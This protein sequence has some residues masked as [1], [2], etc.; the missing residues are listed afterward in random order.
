MRN[1]FLVI[2]LVVILSLVGFCFYLRTNY[3]VP[4]LMYHRITQQGDL[5]LL[6]VSPES[7]RW[8]M[9]FLKEHNYNVI[10][11]SSLVQAMKDKKPLPRNTV[12]ITFDDGYEDNYISAYPTIEEYDLPVT[13]FMIAGYV[14]RSD[15][16]TY[17]QM[18]EMLSSGLVDI[19]SH[20]LDGDY[21]PGKTILEL[22][23]EISSS[24]LRLGENLKVRID[25]F[26]YPLGGFSP[27]IQEL[28]KRY[29]YKAACTTNRGI[30]NTHRN[31]D[32][33]A[34]K[35]IKIKDS[36]NPLFF[37]VKLS[38]YYNLFRRIREPY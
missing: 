15:Y 23:E 16:L 29:N 10:S 25:L 21:L 37:W 4:I 31:D 6:N 14:N 1:K 28:I 34:L 22:T 36:K 30:K 24:K 38:G 33:F 12:V 20:S 8:Q 7:F 35:R 9:R 5:P 32:L 2:I 18:R 19:G 11:L 27:K 13:I 3:V 26:C 17:P